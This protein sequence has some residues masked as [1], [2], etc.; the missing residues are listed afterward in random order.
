MIRLLIILLL[1]TGTVNGQQQFW[2][3]NKPVSVSLIP[4]NISIRS[5]EM[6]VGTFGD[7][8]QTSD[9]TVTDDQKNDLAGNP[10]LE[11]LTITTSGANLHRQVI[12]GLTPLHTYY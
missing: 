3:M 4:Q 5:Q 10:T 12:S 8:W 2:A 6:G 7:G 1:F 11:K 9:I